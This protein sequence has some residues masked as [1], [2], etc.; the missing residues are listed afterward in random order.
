MR[1]VPGEPS[2]PPGGGS[3]APG[4]PT[5][6]S[7]LQETQPGGPPEPALGEGGGGSPTPGA[8]THPLRCSSAS[9]WRSVLLLGGRSPTPGAPTPSHFPNMA[10]GCA[11]WVPEAAIAPL[12]SALHAGGQAAFRQRGRLHPGVRARWIPPLPS[13][14]PASGG[15][16]SAVPRLPSTNTTRECKTG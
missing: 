3:P 15:G 16:G 10:H 14:R 5:T 2:F 12:R 13:V 7:L 9:R 4:A 11:H 1:G 8:P 6:S